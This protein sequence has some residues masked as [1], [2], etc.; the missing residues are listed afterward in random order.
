MSGVRVCVAAG[1]F[2]SPNSLPQSVLHVLFILLPVDE[3]FGMLPVL[4]WCAHRPVQSVCEGMFSSLLSRHLGVE[5]EGCM[6]KFM[7]IF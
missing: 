7:L 5:L 1:S 6:V 2:L 4:G 3:M